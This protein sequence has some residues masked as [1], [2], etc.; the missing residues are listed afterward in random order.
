MRQATLV[1]DGKVVA[2]CEEERFSREKHD[3]RFPKLAIEYVMREGGVEDA[4]RARPRHLLLLVPADVSRGQ[5]PVELEEHSPVREA[6]VWL[7]NTAMKVFNKLAGYDNNRS[8]RAFEREMGA[9]LPKE[10]FKAVPHHLCHVASTFYDSPF[11][12]ALCVTLDAEGES[13]SGMM[14]VATAPTSRCCARRTRRTRSGTCTRSC[15]CS[16]VRQAR[17]VQGDGAGS[18]RQA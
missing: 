3:A 14:A 11:E 10:K 8:H 4:R 7:P 2:A 16:R 15:R 17:R 9:S 18:V 1:V 5:V 12:R 6:G 13:V